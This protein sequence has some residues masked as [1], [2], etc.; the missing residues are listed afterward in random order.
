MDMMEVRRRVMLSMASGKIPTKTFVVSNTYSNCQQLLNDIIS[1]CGSGEF[2]AV[3]Q[4]S[5]DAFRNNGIYAITYFA[6][7]TST[8]IRQG[9]RLR[10]GEWAS[11]PMDTSYDASIPI[12]DE[13]TVY[14]L[15][16]IDM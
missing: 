15:D 16:S 8:P 1:S 14:I 4:R 7:K 10:G 12:G 13:Y 6:N 11:V 2:I 3:S 9:L 5:I